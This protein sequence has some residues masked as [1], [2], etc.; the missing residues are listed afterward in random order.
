MRVGVLLF[1][2]LKTI[3]SFSQEENW[4][5]YLAQYEDGVGSTIVNMELINLAPIN[6]YPFV[7]V[8]GVTFSDCDEAGFPT[9]EEFDNLYDISDSVVHFLTQHVE[10]IFSGTF[11]HQCE[12][13]DY[14][15]LTDTIGVRNL[16]SEMYEQLFSDYSYYIN[17]KEDKKWEYYLDFL[18][19]NEVTQ[20]Y[21]SNGFVLE[22]LQEAG[23]DLTEKRQVDHWLYFKDGKNRDLFAKLMEEEGFTIEGKGKEKGYEYNYKL[24]ISRVDFVDI[25]SISEITLM[26]TQKS[27]EFNGEYDGWETFVIVK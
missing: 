6:N 15:Y 13:L 12:R 4:Q 11:T 5:V 7:L 9:K 22:Q 1:C 25:E 26:L 16:L 2:L 27:A 20:E 24:Q 19:P 21:I 3:L 17:L 23:D 10:H 14:I 8:T 18:Y